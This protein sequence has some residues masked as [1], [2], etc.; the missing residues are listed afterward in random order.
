MSVDLPPRTW[1][2]RQLAVLAAIDIPVLSLRR[3][4]APGA[5]VAGLA[6]WSPSD[7]EGPLA[8][9]L[10]RALGVPLDGLPAVLERAGV[11]IPPAAELRASAAAKRQLWRALRRLRGRSP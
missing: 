8:K 10:A 3:P 4:S 1:S 7:R 9:A 6:G 2:R 11:I 5:M